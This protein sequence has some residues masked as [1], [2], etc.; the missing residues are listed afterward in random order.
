MLD[1]DDYPLYDWR[2][3]NIDDQAERTLVDDY[4]AWSGDFGG[5]PFHD[6]GKI[7]K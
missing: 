4:F 7:F 6:Q 3:V 2:R 5:K 1:C